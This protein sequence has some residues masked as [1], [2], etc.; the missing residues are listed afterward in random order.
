MEEVKNLAVA[1]KTSRNMGLYILRAMAMFLV[2]VLHFVG[3]G[4]LLSHAVE[5]SVKYWLLSAVQIVAFCCVNLYGLTTG[6]LMCDQAFRLSRVVKLWATTLFWSVAVSCVLFVIFP[7]SRTMKEMVSMFFPLLRGRY[8]FFTAYFVVMMVSPALN[9]LIRNLTVGQYRLLLAALFLVFGVIPVGA[10]GNDVLRIS[11]GHHFSWLIVL[12]LIGGY[13]KKTEQTRA[14]S[15]RKYLA[16][17][18]LF[19]AVH[20]LYRIL[21]TAVGLGA[22]SNLLLTYPSPVVVGEAICLFL[23]C[24]DAFAEVSARSIPGKLIRFAA[25]GVYSVYIIHVHPQVYWKPEIV[26]LFRAWDFWNAPAVLGAMLVT[27]AAVF[28]VCVCLDAVRQRLFRCL[29]IDEALEKLSDRT[30]A[31]V[32]KHIL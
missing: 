28:V 16:G 7:E 26:N 25:P 13:F 10:L 9:L 30:E 6:Y 18:F 5:G 8:W 17:F 27:T 15:P 14:V 4:G 32:R 2:I 19:A 3:Q 1:A 24:K 21:T 29:G 11:T 22:F 12:Y 23:Y 20:L 31:C